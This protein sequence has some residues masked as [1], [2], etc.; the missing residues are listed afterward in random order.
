[1]DVSFLLP[2]ADG[3]SKADECPAA[4]SAALFP[5]RAICNKAKSISNNALTAER[6]ARHSSQQKFRTNTAFMCRGT[7]LEKRGMQHKFKY[8]IKS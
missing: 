4:C 2:L 8:Q 6:N 7:A 3:W 5:K 1:M